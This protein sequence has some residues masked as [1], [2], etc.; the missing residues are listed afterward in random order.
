MI[1]YKK[2][3]SYHEITLD[4]NYFKNY[5]SQEKDKENSVKF[6]TTLNSVI[7]KIISKISKNVNIQ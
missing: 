2:I 1:Y 3:K 4:Y 5:L 7:R 6:I